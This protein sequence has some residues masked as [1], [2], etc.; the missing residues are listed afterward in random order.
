MSDNEFPIKITG[1]ASQ[2]KAAIGAA[3]EQLDKASKSVEML[4]DLIGVKIPDA[5]TKLIASS[6]LAGPA[7]EAIFPVVAGLAAIDVL[8]QLGEKL[9]ALI[10]DTFIFTDAQKDEDAALRA[11]NKALYDAT[12]R[13]KQY[14]RERQIAAE[15]TEA[16]K[17]KLRLQ[18]N[19][20]DIGG[21]SAAL[22]AQIQSIDDQITE[23]QKKVARG[24]D[25]SKIA[26]PQ[27][28]LRASITSTSRAIDEQRNVLS[29]YSAQIKK[30]Q[31]DRERLHIAFIQAEA[32][33][34]KGAQDI[35]NDLALENAARL[36]K[37]IQTN[38]AQ[39][40]ADKRSSDAEIQQKQQVIRELAAAH[41]ISAE[42]ELS[43]NKTILDQK[44]A[45]DETALQKKLEQLSRDPERN[46]T[47]IITVQ[48]EI[49]AL[50]TQHYTELEK[51]NADYY[52]QVEHNG[53]EAVNKAATNI[54]ALL[55]QVKES[56]QIIL[57]AAKAH[58]T[59]LGQL[60][61]QRLAFDLSIGKISESEYERRL[62]IQL[63]K[64]YENEKAKLNLKLEAAKGDMVETA[65]INAELEKLEDKHNSDLE[66]ADENSY[67]RRTKIVD[68]FFSH[69]KSGMDSAISGMLKGT[70]SFSKAMQ[71][72]W[73]DM[74]V[75]VAQYLADMMLKWVQH[76][77]AM[78]V[79]HATEKE[80]EVAADASAAAESK[81]IS[82]ADAI[83]KI[84][85]SA[86][87]AA[88]RVYEA[89]A[90]LGPVIAGL[91]AA[92][93]Y[94]AVLGFKAL[95][96]A[97]GGQ[98]YVPN[99]Q[100]TMLH[101]QEMVLPAGIANQMRSVIG[102]G[103]SGGSGVTVVVNNSVSAVDAASFQGHIR[104]HSNM[105]ANE[106]TRALKRKG[107]R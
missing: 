35:S 29:G 37:S 11:S 83:A 77:V 34:K 94:T 84:H 56:Q 67:K 66:K 60:A 22:K 4:A 16:G 68:A 78:L 13:V 79:V 23:L 1:D 58:E 102:G 5:L 7:L 80:G 19:L 26:K 14:G 55:Q 39:V 3:K 51:L 72:M 12:L 88:S 2:A 38:I 96:S 71:Q 42:D 63:E 87:A 40:E 53:Q 54:R 30:L 62:A 48:G 20:E 46:A 105:I 98:Y 100:L 15:A 104:R 24:I 70:E 31:S 107:V 69:M 73:A 103:G 76:H 9:G 45:Q 99:N 32:V 49:K 10:S 44:F 25:T 91:L 17:D 74:V 8:H 21:S 90:P 75:S 50:T 52:K 27:D 101:P 82:L 97:E 85:H 64:T 28:D 61:E 18:F 59:A 95:A 86:A 92:G 33:E 93:T 81:G 47:Q 43:L 6:E 65:R 89:E 41:Q 36:Q 106:V 57:E